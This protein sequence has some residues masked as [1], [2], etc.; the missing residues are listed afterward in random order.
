M[1]KTTVNGIEYKFKFM[2]FDYSKMDL[3][4][5]LSIPLR[6]R[7]FMSHKTICVLTYIIDID[8]EDKLETISTGV[9]YCSK[10]DIYNKK[11][12]RKKTMAKAFEDSGIDKETRKQI[13]AEYFKWCKQ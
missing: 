5:D 3:L 6:I 7:N 4:E 2:H 1:F 10:K 11:I 9:T 12:G 13:W 8:S